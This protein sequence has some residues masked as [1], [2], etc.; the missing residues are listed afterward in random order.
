MHTR[1]TL[2]LTTSQFSMI[3]TLLS[4]AGQ[5]KSDA[6]LIEEMVGKGIRRYPAEQMVKQR[7]RFQESKSASF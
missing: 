3:G 5:D 2:H 4:S 7:T 6:A 1:H